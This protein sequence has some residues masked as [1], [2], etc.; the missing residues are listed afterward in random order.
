MAEQ[1][2]PRHFVNNFRTYDAP[3]AVKIRLFVKNQ[4]IK[5]RKGSGCCG[6]H[7]EPGC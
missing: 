7:G 5:A 1:R 6:N 3:L 4:A 2:H